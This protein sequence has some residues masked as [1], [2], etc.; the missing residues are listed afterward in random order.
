MQYLIK[1]GLEINAKRKDG[2]TCLHG[3]AFIGNP[4]LVSF[5][6]TR[7]G[8][9]NI[10]MKEGATPV[11]IAAGAGNRHALQVFADK[12][13]IDKGEVQKMIDEAAAA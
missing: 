10:A 4:E 12:G 9:A 13:I 2:A 8:D 3:A 11:H 5:L 7:G 1:K 6:L